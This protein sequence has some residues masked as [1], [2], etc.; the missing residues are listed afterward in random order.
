MRK[1]LSLLVSLAI[2]AA[3]YWRIDLGRMAAAFQQSRWGW[4]VLGLALVV[5]LTL[6]TAHRLQRLMPAGAPLRLGEAVSLTLAASVLNLVLPSKMGDLAKSYF[7]RERGRLR[8]SLALSVVVFEKGWDMLSLLVWCLLGLVLLPR[9]GP[10]FWVL[11]GAVALGLGAG[12]LLLGAPAAAAGL[13]RTAAGLAPAAAA[14][15]LAGLAA[16]WQELLRSQWACKRRMAYVIGLSLA[17]WLLHLLQIWF[18]VLALRGTAPFLV[19][20]GLAPLAILAGLL[21]LT[22][23]G[24]GTRDA[25]LIV[26]FHGYLAAPTAAA[27]GVLCTL[28]YVM[29]AIAGLPLVG[30]YLPGARATARPVEERPLSL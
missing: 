27:L 2:L 11:S 5:P 20:L 7:M 26:L 25:A 13:F 24:V 19:T 12:V 15:K 8:G 10:L 16:D 23:A 18:F 3:I 1:L 29:P 28:R 30:R 17:I 4:L 9:A 22:F 6:L 21:P 14:R